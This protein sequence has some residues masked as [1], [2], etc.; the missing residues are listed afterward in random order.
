[1]RENPK[2][3]PQN[4][5]EEVV[6]QEIVQN[7]E[8]TVEEIISEMSNEEFEA[9]IEMLMRMLGFTFIS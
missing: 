6:Y 5:Q 1:M 4:R 8:K 3:K 7:P 2:F 9:F